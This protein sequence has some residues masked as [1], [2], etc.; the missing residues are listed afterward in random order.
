MRPRWVTPSRAARPCARQ[1][2]VGAS[3]CASSRLPR[4]PT[5]DVQPLSS[6]FLWCLRSRAAFLAV[7][8]LLACPPGWFSA[9]DC[10]AGDLDKYKLCADNG[11][12]LDDGTCTVKGGCAPSC[13]S[14]SVLRVA[15]TQQC[16]LCSWRQQPGLSRGK[17]CAG[18]T[19]QSR[20][21]TASGWK[22]LSATGPPALSP[23]V[24]R[25]LCCAVAEA[26]HALLRLWW[27]RGVAGSGGAADVARGCRQ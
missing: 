16:M 8:T 19:L 6:M 14:H 23:R 7:S 20:E 22:P 13:S 15:A 25:G 18:S 11:A 5:G 21:R 27:S 3:A 1:K 10:S 4:A 2:M 24:R 9:Q 17:G 26:Y 12:V